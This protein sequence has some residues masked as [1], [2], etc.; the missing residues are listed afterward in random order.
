MI[1]CKAVDVYY[2]STVMPILA[3]AIIPL[4]PTLMHKPQTLP[5]HASHSPAL[6]PNSI[7]LISQN[8]TI[9][10]LCLLLVRGPDVL[11]R[12]LGVAWENASIYCTLEVLLGDFLPPAEKSQALSIPSEALFELCTSSP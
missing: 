4:D 8:L 5:G 1:A 3:S 2:H 6:V 9:R 12:C 11:E 7:M 10:L